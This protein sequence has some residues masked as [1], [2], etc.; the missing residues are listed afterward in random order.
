MKNKYLTITWNGNSNRRSEKKIS[1]IK[2]YR[3]LT[4]CDLSTAKDFVEKYYFHGRVNIL[5]KSITQDE[6]TDSIFALNQ[7]GMYA[8]AG[9]DDAEGSLEYGLRTLTVQAVTDGEYGVAEQLLG[10]LR[11]RM[12]S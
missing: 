12:R 11:N 9:S 3:T 5:N 10:I 6:L 7:Y 8:V 2:A 4:L 1:A